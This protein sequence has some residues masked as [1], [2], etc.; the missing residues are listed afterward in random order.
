MVD[1]FHTLSSTLASSVAV[2]MTEAYLHA[3]IPRALIVERDAVN[4]SI[5]RKEMLKIL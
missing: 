3:H 2:Y 5:S 1:I 4:G